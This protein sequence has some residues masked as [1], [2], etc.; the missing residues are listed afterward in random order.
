MPDLSQANRYAQIQYSF[1]QPTVPLEH[2]ESVKSVTC[3]SDTELDLSF[4]QSNYFN[5]AISSWPKSGEPF[6]L[7]DST[8][9]CGQSEQ[10]TFFYVTD[11]T[12][13]NDS[14][15]VLA[16]GR[17][18][19]GADPSIIKSLK[20]SWGT[21]QPSSTTP[22]N[23]TITKAPTTA[24]GLNKRMGGSETKSVTV[25]VSPSPSSLTN[26]PWGNAVHIGAVDGVTVWCV[27]CG[28]TG[29]VVL[30]GSIDLSLSDPFDPKLDASFDV[31]VQ[32]FNIPMTFGFQ[33]KNAV[34]ELPS[35]TIN[36]LEV[37]LEG[38]GFGV[39]DVF[40]VGT[41]FTLGVNF[42]LAVSASGN[43]E[44]GVKMAWPDAKAHIDAIG[45]GAST[46]S[47]WQPTVDK[48]WNASAGQMAIN[49]SLGVPLSLGV[50]LD[51]PLHSKLN[52]NVSITDTPSIELDSVFNTPANQK[53]AHPRDLEIRQDDTNCAN[54]VQE[55]V[56]FNDIIGINVLNLYKTTLASWGTTVFSTCIE[57]GSSK[58]TPTVSTNNTTNSSPDITT[59]TSSSASASTV[60]PNNTSKSSP[61][62]TATTSSS[63]STSTV[64]PNNTSNSSPVFTTTTSSPDRSSKQQP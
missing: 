6:I 61:D 40:S 10:R 23:S 4:S 49:G 20:A 37:P 38:L 5:K 56:K 3:P 50:G 1:H 11:Y 43:L 28:A 41:T 27:D 42:K 30:S 14:L 47:G 51:I 22:S 44:A 24:S 8:E 25:D 12:V 46:H 58:S 19:S 13:H 57:T 63:T 29:N 59:T 31:E 54:G 32:D 45:G 26:S 53:R 62:I 48:V 34:A 55:I 9:G 35:P 18:L 39:P 64:S 21:F 15:S 36:I 2:I 17:M 52:T 7:I 16:H 33:A 60:S